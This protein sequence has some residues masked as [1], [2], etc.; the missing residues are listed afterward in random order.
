M[1]LT[2]KQKLTASSIAAVVLMAVILTTLSGVKLLNETSSNIYSRSESIA[3][4]A[5]EGISEWVDIRKN[6]ASAFNDN[7]SQSDVVPFLKQARVSGGFDDIF[8]GTVEGEMLRSHP[9]RNRAGYDPRE[10]PWYKDALIANQQIVTTAY[11]DAITNELLVTIAEPLYSGSQLKGVVGADVLLDQLVSDVINLDVG[12]NSYAMLIESVDG[13]FLVHPDK[14]LTLKSIDRLSPILSMPFVESA[15][16]NNQVERIFENGKEK[17]VYFYRVAGTSWILSIVMDYETEAA[18][19]IS[20]LKSLAFTALTVTLFVAFVISVL[21]NFLFKDLTRVS[22]A[23]KNIA[24]GEADLTQ[25]ITPRYDD[26]VGRIANDFNLFVENMHGVVSKLNNVSCSLSNQARITLSQ[27]EVRS[28]RIVSQQDDINMVATAIDEMGAATQEVAGNAENTAQQ[29]DQAVIACVHGTD[30]VTQTHKS[31]NSLEA[32]VQSATEIMKELELHANSINSIIATIQGVA[33]QTNLLALNAAIEAARAGE[34]GRGF[35][36]VAD[37]VRVLSQRTHASTTEIQT[38]IDT[39]QTTTV[40][41][42]SIMNHSRELAVTSVEDA[43]L[44]AVS[45]DQIQNSVR[46][47]NDMATQIASAAEEQATVTSEISR[48]TIGIRDVSNEL[49]SE[50]QQAAAQASELSQLSEELQKEIG[51]FKL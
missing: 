49:S 7:S 47:I 51:R 43:N 17:L 22:D 10:R 8:F 39:L 15:I 16:R 28:Q 33:E 48:N 19:N 34:Q 4:T 29:S 32:E 24:S 41:A 45:L 36:V 21:V 50:S 38:M 13:T 25:R 2:L 23:M 30:R 31:I 14:S 11:Q 46:L 27:S 40:K 5:S 9:E 1:K 18:G 26:E 12:L 6:I 44:A 3:A 42:V 37:E 20:L 35:A